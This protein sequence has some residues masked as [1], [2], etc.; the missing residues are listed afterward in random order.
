VQRPLATVVI[1][2]L[3]IATFLTLFVLPILYISFENKKVKKPAVKLNLI[4]LIILISGFTKLNAQ[5]KI[6][7]EAATDSALKNNLSIKDELLK[8]EYHKKLIKSAINIPQTNAIAEVGQINSSYTDIRMGLAQNLNFPTIYARQSKLAKTELAVAQ[9]NVQLKEKD[10]KKL[11]HQTFYNYLYLKEKEKLLLKSDSI[12]SEFYEKTIS[13]LEKGESNLLEKTTAE[14]Q[15]GNI[16]NQLNAL[17]QELDLSLLYFQLILNTKNKYF[18]FAKNLKLSTPEIVDSSV[19]F[20]HPI[21]KI[22][23]QQKNVSIA[24][25]KLEK[26]HFLPDLNF[27]LFSMSM[28]GFGSDEVFYNRSARFN[29]AQVGIG[30]PLFFG[31]FKAKVK[32]ASIATQIADNNIALQSQA[33][34]NQIESLNIQYRGNL[35]TVNY[36][37][38]KGLNNSAIIIKTANDQFFNGEINYLDWGI[39]INQAILI[40]SNYLDAIKLLNESIISINYFNTKF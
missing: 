10:V 27:G 39:L 36:F 3:L 25:Y 35:N 5:N 33:L 17:K 6:S 12:Y 24:N 2:G 14:T 15:L 32:A 1:G 21:L 20:Q 37:E 23:L 31:S 40:Q 11:V 22:A 8:A 18:P 4:L 26:S 7:L 38:N 29:S 19:F 28:Q 9:L 30:I 13:R 34:K 16:K